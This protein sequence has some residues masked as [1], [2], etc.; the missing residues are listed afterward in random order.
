MPKQTTRELP[1]TPVKPDVQLPAQEQDI[2]TYWDREK[3]F[4]KSLDPT[5]RK[6]YSFYDGPPFATGLPHYGHI[7]AG[8]L[9]D[10]VP[11]Y[12]TM[13]G[14]TVPRRFG[15]DCHGLPVEY[16]INKAHKIESRKDVL[17][18]GVDKY[19][20]ACR[21]IVERYSEEWKKT[22]R[23]VGRWVDMDK[24]YFTMDVSFMQ[25]VWWVF[26][27]LY[28]RGLIYEGYKVVPYSVGIST[29]LSNFEANLNYKMVQDPAITI[30]FPV[31][32]QP[33]VSFLAW[34]TTPWT[35]P[36]NLALA[37]NREFDYVKARDKA[38][39]QIYIV[40]QALLGAVFK[41]PAKEAEILETVKGEKLLGLEY[42][43][44]FPFFAD[45]RAKGAF[46][47]IHSD[48]V[49][50]ESGTGIVHM[51]PA[52]GEEDYFACAKEGVPMVN[53]VDDDGTFTAEVPTYQGRRVK[54]ADKDIIA[55]LKKNGRLLKQE[56]LDHSYPFCYRSDTPLIYRAVSSW[57]VAV[58]KI[59]DKVVAAN[60]T[61]AWV[62]DHLRDGRFGN[63]LENARDW[64]VSRNRFWGT[65]IPIWRNPE[66][67]I[68]CIGS[69]EE[70]ERLSG[71][72]VHDLHIDVVDKIT[73]PSPTG[74]SPLRRVEG[75]LDCWFE[76][77]SMPYAQWGYPHADVEAFKKAF[78]AD[79]IAEGLD[80][81]RGW[82]YTLMVIGA[83]LFD[84]AP[85]RNV[86]VNG[87][88]LAEDGRKMSKSLRNYP[89]PMEVLDRHGADALRLYLI[90]SPVVKAQELKF[91]ENGVRDIVRKILLRW[92]N[93]YSFFVSYA[94]IDRFV[95]K[96]DAK[97]SPNILDQWVMSRLHSLIANTQREMTAYRLYN[98]VPQLLQ[99]I[100]ELTNT[101]IR[102]NRS[103][104]WQDGM[105]EDKR[106]A[107]ETLHE[108]LLTLS[109]LMAPFAPFLAESTYLNLSGVL[110]ESG[111][112]QSVHLES[113]PEADERRIHRE[114]EEAVG[115]MEALVTL[116][117]NQREKIG[118]KA[119][120]P[121]RSMRIIHRDA[122]LLD[123]L[124]KFEAYFKDELNI[125]TISY[126]SNE[127]HY[128][129]VTAKA[130]FPI[131]GKR[132]GPK[133]K[134]V[135]G[136]IQKLPLTSLLELEAGRPVLVEGEPITLA[137]IEIRREAKGAHPNLATHPRVSIELDPTVT[138]EQE[139]EGLARE[140]TRKIQQARKN[141]DF[142]LDDRIALELGCDGPLRTAAEAH[143]EMISC[144]TLALEFGFAPQPS[145]EH[146]EEADIDG[147]IVKIGIRRL[148]R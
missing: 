65:P 7:L 8:V 71:Q 136:A 140:I 125:Q 50:T 46:R 146:T 96:G 127:D 148:R 133:M 67:E 74:K 64:A 135:A 27:E 17:R 33:G 111:R 55:E 38:S 104:F 130:N 99:F 93:S 26:Q 122:A 21:G 70:L 100:E 28:K 5:G 85:F 54:D 95:P 30:T 137:D 49:T 94:N 138:P 116:G 72:K 91:S 9:K 41:D 29:P 6:T 57:F 18:M 35:L 118:V 81:T 61:T 110:P 134:A 62:P 106:L 13:K 142:N 114:L 143:R 112:K 52:F 58:E 141:A 115:A 66:G 144:E 103:H 59:K 113:F 48:H 131:L 97:S 40:A 86:V 105:P 78:P 92:W 76:S 37:V 11:R 56:T 51:A 101:Y 20:A 98:V 117:R 82:F 88:V 102:F 42:E 69:R 90:D 39:G 63:W 121:L 43:P 32:G 10:V 68:L 22:V 4:Q 19:N 119:K 36:S 123:N 1:Y 83:A 107:Y 45:R 79:F 128:V 124:K 23:R 15:W 2:L 3:I 77:G 109:R 75:V 139:R 16:E 120:I 12:W 34:T 129:Q 126:D 44:L 84:Q 25:S 47:V 147:E 108:V 87:L 53:P 73:I 60:K 132:L 145:G 31:L 24:P 80:Q 14:Y 89:D